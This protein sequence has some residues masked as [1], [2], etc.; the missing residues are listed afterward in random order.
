MMHPQFDAYGH[1]VG[2]DEPE[3][4][5]YEEDEEVEEDED[6]EEEEEEDHSFEDHDVSILL[7]NILYKALPSDYYSSV[8]PS[9]VLIED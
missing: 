1:V 3:E 4:G 2:D 8:G 7:A 6:E 5:E 9:S